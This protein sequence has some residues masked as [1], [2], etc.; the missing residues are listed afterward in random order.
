MSRQGTPGSILLLQVR[1]VE[2]GVAF[3]PY[4]VN[5]VKIYDMNFLSLSIPNSASFLCGHQDQFISNKL[6]E[7]F[8][9]G[10]NTVRI[11]MSY[12]MVGDRAFLFI[13]IIGTKI[14]SVSYT[15]Y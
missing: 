13:H 1:F 14:P 10:F 9:I 3:T 6:I 8:S 4:S 15:R 2:D 7:P 12:P 5:D 11:V